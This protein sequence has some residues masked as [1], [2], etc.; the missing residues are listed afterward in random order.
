MSDIY[1][2]NNSQ[3]FDLL[4]GVKVIGDRHTCFKKG[5]GIGMH[6]GVDINAIGPY[7][8]IVDRKIYCGKQQQLP[9]RYKTFGSNTECLQKGIGVGK[10]KHIETLFAPISPFIRGDEVASATTL[11]MPA[12]VWWIVFLVEYIHSKRNNEEF[13]KWDAVKKST[14]WWLFT[15]VLISLQNMIF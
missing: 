11:L 7:Q 14:V 1:C 6:S 4:N 3:H 12:V 8:P 13:D 2:G 15:W 10:R 5:V 9:Q